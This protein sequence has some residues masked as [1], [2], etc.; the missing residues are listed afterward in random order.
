M[1]YVITI[2]Q[3]KPVSVNKF[4]N[5]YARHGLKKKDAATIHKQCLLVDKIPAAKGK[6]KVDTHIILKSGKGRPIDPDNVLK[7]L[8]DA[9]VK[10]GMLKDDS[11]KWC[12]WTK[13]T[14]EKGT[15]TVW[16]TRITLEDL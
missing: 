4:R 9:L 8:L 10:C 16:G 3:W 12:D 2:P 6:R 13:P 1:K 15:G 7:S 14:L 11:D 5:P